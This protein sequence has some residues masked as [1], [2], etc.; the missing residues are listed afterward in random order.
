MSTETNT[1]DVTDTENLDSFA[2][3]LFGESKQQPSENANSKDAQVDEVE[4]NDA[5]IQ[6]ED[7]QTPSEDGTEDDDNTDELAPTETDDNEEE[8]SGEKPKKLN[9]YQERINELT[10]ARRAA[11]REAEEAKRERDELLRNL[12]E[13][14]PKPDEPKTK[15]DVSPEAG[16]REPLPND[17]NEDG[18]DKYPLG[19]YDPNYLRDNMKF[20]FESQE[21]ERKTQEAQAAQQRE[22]DLARATLQAT[23]N[24][25]L[26]D[27]QER[28]PDFQDKG[29]QM[30][31]VFEGIDQNYGQYLTDTIME[32]D[33][34]PDVF[35]YLSN[36]IDEAEKIVN[37]GPRK[38]TIALAELGVQLSD[39]SQ[40]P[41]GPRVKVSKAPTPP[42]QVKGSAVV[43][44]GPK[45]DTDDLDAFSREFFKKK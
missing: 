27:A 9:R 19:V 34:G 36:N 14:T 1:S 2:S 12:E 45:P 20:M 37:A 30:L 25:K 43:R 29:E 7:T 22:Q 3:E 17:K 6:D 33:A 10:A 39:R 26:V 5:P 31:A 32:M 44:A 8:D 4:D 18:S 41:S 42:P 35:Y 21:A 28:Y 40:K 24:E 11:E 15:T 23:W 38:A 13:K 16:P